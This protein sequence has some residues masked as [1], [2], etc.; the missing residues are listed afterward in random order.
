MRSFTGLCNYYRKF[1]PS[2]AET[3]SPL[4][5]LLQDNVVFDWTERHQISFEKIR[6][7]LIEA[8]V[9]HYP[10]Y[11]L[12][13]VIQTDASD[14]GLGAVLSQIVN[15]EERVVQYISRVLQPAEKPWAPREKEALAIIYACE[16]FRPY[17]YMSKFLIE[18]DHH[19]LQWLM[20]AKSPARL[21]RWALRLCEFDFDIRY[22]RAEANANADAL[23]RLPLLTIE[24]VW[25]TDEIV[26]IEDIVMLT[27][28]VPDHILDV[29]MTTIAN[30][31]T[32]ISHEEMLTAQRTDLSLQAVIA[33]CEANG[34]VSEKKEFVIDDGLLF[35]SQRGGKRLLVIPWNMIEKV[36]YLY[37]NESMTVHL[38]RDRLYQ[39]LRSRFYWYGMFADCSRWVNSCLKCNQVKPTQPLNHG[40]L[41]PIV[42]TR[43]FEIVG[44]DIL[45]PVTTSEDGNSYILVCVDLYTSWIEA[46]PLKTITSA[47][48]GE[49][50]F[51]LIISR[52]TCPETVIT[53]QGRQLVSKEFEKLL[54][55]FG[56]KHRTSSAY[57]HQTNGKV[58]RFN[59]FIENGLAL[60]VK[61]DQTNW[62]KLLDR[63]LFTYRVSLNRIL[64][65]TPFFLIY[66]R[67]GVMPQD[68][69]IGNPVRNQRQVSELDQNDYKANLLKVLKQA[70]DKLN[71]QKED[72]SRKMKEYYDLSQKE[73]EFKV[74]DEVWL[75][76]P[77]PTPGLSRKLIGF[78]EGPHTV[79]GK[80]DA[81]TYRLK[82]KTRRSVKY[83]PAHVKRLRKHKPWTTPT[84]D[85]REVNNSTVVP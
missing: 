73:V 44:A 77:A 14:D 51:N 46:L 71:K 10:D 8:P 36:L 15:G 37:H 53:D 4:Y 16:T 61:D 11:K 52:H 81:V 60:M 84:A 39:M 64:D 13:F 20:T 21:V 55:G 49:A 43:P 50:F 58:E 17:I 38:A 70:Y 68:L 72:A 85:R 29:L 34:N 31:V 27:S 78:W 41:Q 69:M 74:D 22:R 30:Q 76:V 65:E 24:E 7:L 35:L 56:I 5:E 62:D 26:C 47:E 18:T 6:Q 67:D 2:F 1:I 3:C 32:R 75:Y 45:G 12:P 57:H 28:L 83:T 54:S 48:V 40:L 42:T 80:L 63:V 66:G 79:V 25:E 59:K 82:M 9:L 19:S 23:S 33:E